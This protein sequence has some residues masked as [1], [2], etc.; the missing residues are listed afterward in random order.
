M[1]PDVGECARR[2]PRI[3]LTEDV[4]GAR[5]S[6]MGE[7]RLEDLLR[8]GPVRLDPSTPRLLGPAPGHGV[9]TFVL[10]STDKAVTRRRRFW[11]ACASASP[12]SCSWASVPW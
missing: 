3:R 11:F 6:E 7:M 10:I 5:V 2:L 4:G 9:G 8:R 1:G 12:G